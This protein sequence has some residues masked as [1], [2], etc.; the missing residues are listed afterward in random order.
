M[1]VRH[2]L[3]ACKKLSESMP[4]GFSPA[5]VP[6]MQTIRRMMAWRTMMY[7]NTENYREH[8]YP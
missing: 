6:C 4:P 3:F 5:Q 8:R 2:W 1:L 7:R